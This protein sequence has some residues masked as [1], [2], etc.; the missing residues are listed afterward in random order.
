MKIQ[1]PG[2]TCSYFHIA[3]FVDLVDVVQ[4]AHRI[5]EF[6][7]S[8]SI[9]PL[10]EAGVGAQMLGQRAAVFPSFHR[11]ILDDL[12]GVLADAAAVSSASVGQ[13]PSTEVVPAESPDE[14][15][16]PVAVVRAK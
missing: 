11:V 4:V 2:K 8:L 15:A 14:A 1:R 3:L 5:H 16:G 13:P 12:V 7:Q 6:I 10:V 9:D